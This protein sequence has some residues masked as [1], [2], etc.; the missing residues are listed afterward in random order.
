M[1]LTKSP[2]D[3]PDDVAASPFGWD[4]GAARNCLPAG[5]ASDAMHETLSSHVTRHRL[6]PLPI[7]HPQFS[8]L[9]FALV[10][11]DSVEP[12][13]LAQCLRDTEASDAMH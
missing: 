1:R 12:R 11:R 5:H 4:S 7:L 10:G 3:D 8:I 9:A 13:V 6:F 2:T